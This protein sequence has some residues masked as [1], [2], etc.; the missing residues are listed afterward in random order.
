MDGGVLVLRGVLRKYTAE[1]KSGAF[2]LSEQERSIFGASAAVA[3]VIG[4]GGVAAGAAISATS[5]ELADYVEF[6]IGGRHIRGWVWRSP[7]KEG[8]FVNAVL[9]QQEGSLFDDL[10]AIYRPSDRIIS[11]YPHLS[12]GRYSHAI[13]AFKWWAIASTLFLGCMVLIFAYIFSDTGSMWSSF[14]HEGFLH[15]VGAAV[16]TCY[17]YFLAC[18]VWAIHRWKKYVYAAENVFAALGWQNVRF[19]DLPQSSK[20]LR[21]G[22]EESDYG[23]FYFRY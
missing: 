1:R 19:I 18:T 9:N 3:A 13:N 17:L 22:D 14:S 23:E 20:K 4:E 7:F 2:F 10:L 16:S 6:E 21:R 5:S 8:D 11:L 12:R 15:V